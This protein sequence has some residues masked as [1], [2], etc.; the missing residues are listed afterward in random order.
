MHRHRRFLVYS[1]ILA[2]FTLGGIPAE[3]LPQGSNQNPPKS[4]E[5]PSYK[6]SVRSNLVLV[7][8][9]VID[10]RG[11]HVSGLKT[12]DFEVREDGNAQTIVRMDEVT[13]GDIAKVERPAAAA[14][15][16]TNEVVAEHAKKME[17]IALDQINVPFAGGADG[18]RMLIEF[19][20]KN[21]DSNTLLALVALTHNGV[22]IIHD[23]SADASTLASA[24]GRVHRK[25]SSQ[26]ATSMDVSGENAPADLEVLQLNALLSGADINIAGLSP[27]QAVAAL[28]AASA[29]ARATVDASRRAQ[30]GLITLECFQQ[31]AEYFGGLPGRK[32]L[33]WASTGFPFAL[34]SS[35]NQ[36]TTRGTLDDDWQRTF[37]MLTDANIA[38]Y[39]VDISGLTTGATANNIHTLNSTI[40]KTQGPEGGVGARSQ[41][42][43]ALEGGQFND[44]NVARQ[45]TMRQL[46][47]RTGGQP[48]YNSN[49]G[50]ELF[51]RA[52]QDA[53]QYY[54]LAY[55]TKETGKYGWR[56][57]NVKVK[58]DGVKVRARNGFFFNDPKK[59]TDP[60][61]AIQDLRMAMTSDLNFT[62]VPLKGQW[63]ETQPV[64][65][66]RDVSFMLSIP[67]GVPTIDTDNENHISLDFLVVVTDKTGKNAA[68]ISQRLD[69]RLHPDGVE[70]IQNKGIDYTNILTLLPGDYKVHFVVRDNLRGT[71]GSV[72]SPLTVK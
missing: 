30:E 7:P 32:S 57:L 39:P 45:E 16:F 28:R 29:S 25:V 49:D 37:R 24:L 60:A 8:V 69:T 70:R 47:D 31:I 19:L 42:L 17:I 67:P 54:T 9:I 44:S 12:E 23:F 22:R 62:F 41:G 18:N 43:Q 33:I 21:L 48:F 59:A 65:D 4:S 11:D 34:G 27:A 66:K 40:I 35:T 63:L 58:R 26:D 50:A 56:K 55:Y 71:L 64:G 61:A 6:L 38:V 5:N 13:A 10:K 46:A 2:G 14:N 15:T 53:G 68:N 52:G 51:R 20:L 3:P 72:V 36:S 1:L